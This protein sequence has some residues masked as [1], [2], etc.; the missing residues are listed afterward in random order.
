M[1][2]TDRDH[3]YYVDPGIGEKQRGCPYTF[4][5]DGHDV[6]SF[7]I[8]PD[9]YELTDFKFEAYP[10]DVFYDGKIVAQYK[11][12]PFSVTLKKNLWRYVLIFLT[13][14]G[15][16]TAAVLGFR[17]VRQHKNGIM[18][19]LKIKPKTEIK[20]QPA[21]KTKQGRIAD[22]TKI[23]VVKKEKSNTEVVATEKPVEQEVTSPKE[24]VVEPKKNET[25]TQPETA[26]NSNQESNQSAIL[27]TE[28]F[29]HEFW[30]LIH[31]KARQMGTY[32]D[33]YRKYK[34]SDINC[35]EFSYLYSTILENNYAFDVWK[36]K[37][38]QIPEDEISSINSITT[39]RQELELYE[40]EEDQD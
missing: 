17:F 16:L 31:R 14:I 35:R 11:K 36:A 6:R 30:D 4:Y 15:L 40:D 25:V 37:M 13:I 26:P 39:L 9:G 21:N 18:R 33:L 34:D 19:R 5:K 7:I 2:N 24:D 29:Q 38:I 27:T 8:P 28:Q 20:A 12:I 1:S 23:K 10:D 3:F 22:S 32:G